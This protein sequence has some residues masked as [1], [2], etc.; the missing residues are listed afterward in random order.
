MGH[1]AAGSD[2]TICTTTD[3]SVFTWGDG[4]HGRLGL[5]DDRS[6]KLVPTQVRGKLQNKAVL[7]VAAG[8]HHSTCVTGDGLV[9]S[10]GGNTDGQLGIVNLTGADVPLLSSTPM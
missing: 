5:G 9:Y 4:T 6:N 7:Q 3:G 2:H 10:W 8:D 1:V